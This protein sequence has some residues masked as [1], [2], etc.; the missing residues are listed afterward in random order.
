[1][2]KIISK[3]NIIP[4][5]V[6]ICLILNSGYA[7]CNIK[8][9]GIYINIV[10]AIMCILFIIQYYKKYK[11]DK[12]MLLF[13]AL[14]FMVINT[15]IISGFTNTYTYLYYITSI[16]IGFG[17]S[18]KYN[19]KDVVNVFLNL[20]TVISIISLIG[21]IL[22]NY[23]NTL[24]FLP[25]MSNI[26]DISYG[27]GYIFNYITI[28]PERNCGIFWEPGLFASFLIASII[29]EVCFKEKKI[30]LFRMILFIICI[31]TTKSAAGYRINDTCDSIS[32]I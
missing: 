31:V 17:I 32:N 12:F 6:T 1:M 30:S 13:L 21:Y 22:L 23:T 5:I 20:M 10:L 28:I 19:F 14:I 11:I 16:I 29:L 8:G 27:V 9:Y 26:N 3:K 18:I 15:Y 4:I 2:S 25:I 24:K 7:L